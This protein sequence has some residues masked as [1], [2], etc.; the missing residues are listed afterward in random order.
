MA[1]STP[2]KDMTET[3]CQCPV[4]SDQLKDPKLLPCLHRY[5]RDCLTSV[6]LSTSEGMFKCSVC[7]Q[8]CEIPENGVDG[9]KTDLHMTSRL[10]LNKLQDSFVKKDQK[11][12]CVSCSKES[13]TPTYCFKCDKFLCQECFQIHL[14]FGMFQ[15]H[16]PHTLNLETIKE[17]N[18][19]SETISPFTVDT[20]CADHVTERAQLCCSTC[21]GLPICVTCVTGMHKGHD[22]LDVGELAKSERELLEAKLLDI[23]KNEKKLYELPTKVKSATQKLRKNVKDK[24]E[25]LQIQYEQHVNKM[26]DKINE[27]D[28]EKETQ[29]EDI[30]NRREQEKC[31]LRVKFENEL[32]NLD[33]KYDQE[34]QEVQAEHDKIESNCKITLENF[35]GNL[36]E[37][38]A[39]KELL[40][41]QKENEL[42]DILD[43]C[44]QIIERYENFTATTAS[45][46]A[47]K[48]DWSDSQC[49]PYI[50][51]ASDALVKE[52]EQ[53]FPQ[54]ELLSDFTLD[55]TK[56]VW[57][58]VKVIVDQEVLID[59]EE[60]AAKQ[61]AAHND[62]SVIGQYLIDSITQT[63]DGNMV[64]SGTAPVNYSH[65]TVINSK[66]KI[67]KQD[68]MSR[69]YKINYTN[70]YC[71]YLSEHQVVTVC[72]PNEIGIYDVRNGSYSRKYID[73]VVTTGKRMLCVAYDP[74]KN[75]IIVC[76]EY[77]NV[78]LIFDHQLNY[79][80][81]VNVT[82]GVFGVV[83]DIAVHGGYLLVCHGN[84]AHAITIEGQK[85]KIV[86]E[87]GFELAKPD[88]IA[89]T[90]LGVCIDKKDFIYMLWSN[91]T[92]TCLAQYSKDGRQLLSILPLANFTNVSLTTFDVDGTE[93]LVVASKDSA[94]LYSFRLIAE[95]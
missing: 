25:K 70:R 23:T 44:E 46:L 95:E 6:I 5:C 36:K 34:S 42:Q 58:K 50:R 22:L 93:R 86:F 28:T 71:C 75:R 37:L 78:F 59:F 62:K 63:S 13:T 56:M 60:F 65:I 16:Q 66:G 27:N 47:S 64:I 12:L 40:T 51:T 32:T 88:L 68:Q 31:Q 29:V 55:V 57:G 94:K 84:G 85:N 92:Q 89:N 15:D 81:T 20:M 7:K 3:V 74:D 35:D 91:T 53:E 49:I 77:S 11:Q 1:S 79:S 67:Q 54:L 30:E 4:C 9:F 26:K 39:E 48:D 61:A 83:N 8:D 2:S 18:L 21:G 10:L 76:L 41:R 19:T 52:M 43:Y 45:I 24:S 69:R 90:A 33:Q 73:N 72:A 17:K 82:G 38:S 80:H 14:T 87:F